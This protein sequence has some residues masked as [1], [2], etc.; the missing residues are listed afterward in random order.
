[1]KATFQR[2][3]SREWILG[4]YISSERRRQLL[5]GPTFHNI[6][7][8]IC[9]TVRIVAHKR[10]NIDYHRSYY[11]AE[12]TLRLNAATVD[13]FH[14]SATG[15]RAQYYKAVRNGELANEYAVHKLI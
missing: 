7:R 13:L 8:R 14:N 10:R 9:K 15:Y 5:R 1:M 2:I 11:R 4:P 12:V 6:V 3:S